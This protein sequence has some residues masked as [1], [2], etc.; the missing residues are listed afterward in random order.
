VVISTPSSILS[1]LT[2][3]RVIDPGHADS[4]C[5]EAGRTRTHQSPGSF[6]GIERH[7]IASQKKIDYRVNGIDYPKNA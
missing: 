5:N 7:G 3:E 6:T 4:A 1:A 2:L